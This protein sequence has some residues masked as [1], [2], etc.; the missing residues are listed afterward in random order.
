[1][2]SYRTAVRLLALGQIVSWASLY[3]AFTSFVLPMQRTLG[4]SKPVLMGAFTLGLAVWGVAAVPVG[5]AVDRGHGRLM[6]AGG[7]ALGGVGCL[8]WSQ[9]SAP[10]ML[11]GVWCILGVAMA[12][13]L[14]EP[15]FVV[16]TR[17]FPACY[18]D[19]I[20]TLT[21]AGGFATTLSFAAT[22]WLLDAMG[23]RAALVAIGVVLIAVIA[24]AHAV[25]LRGD[26]G[27]IV[28]PALAA[29][30]IAGPTQPGF[31]ASIGDALRTR[32]FW[33]LVVTFAGY[34]FA[35]AALWAHVVPALAGKGLDATHA[36][37]VLVWVGPAQV[38][39]RLLL[40]AFGSRASPRA[41]GYAVYAGQA[42]AFLTFSLASSTLGLIAF[43]IV[44]GASN[45]LVPT[46]RGSLVPEY[47]GRTHLGR[48]SGAMTSLG[49]YARAAAPLGAAAL[50]ALPMSYDAMMGV[51]AGLSLLTLLTYAA[52][53]KPQLRR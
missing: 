4:W 52:A 6:L 47:F 25:A 19:A 37:A 13:T 42:A 28:D 30:P 46:V 50:L 5:V 23:W 40:K 45:G 18:R 12:M 29:R 8:A 34:A 39:S 11:Y 32:A 3:F 24:P 15:A 33:M 22:A 44:Y 38:G 48:I 43:A 41:L 49:L 17:R 10:W 27:P 53:R 14:Y 20:T 16:V 51:L 35:A 26:D 36:L 31:D 2:S 9:V 21:L 7:A 1:M